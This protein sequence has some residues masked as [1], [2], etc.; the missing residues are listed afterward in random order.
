MRM[1]AEVYKP[2]GLRLWLMIG[3]NV[4]MGLV[5][6][7]ATVGSVETIVASA[8]LFKPFAEAGGAPHG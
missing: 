8:S 6:T 5:A 7:A 4:I 2:R 3:I 1:W